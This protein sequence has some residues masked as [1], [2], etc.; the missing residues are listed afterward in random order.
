M[1]CRLLCDI[2]DLPITA[3]KHVGDKQ[4]NPKKYLP[5]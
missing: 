3:F 5:A 2:S 1:D 4:I